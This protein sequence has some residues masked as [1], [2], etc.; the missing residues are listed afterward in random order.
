MTQYRAE[1][2]ASGF[3]LP[4]VRVEIEIEGVRRTGPA[5]VD[6]GTDHTMVPWRAIKDH[7]QLDR[8]LLP[9]TPE[10]T[11]GMHGETPTY[12][13]LG[14]VVRFAGREVC[15]DFL[16]FPRED[17][18]EVVLGLQDF[19]RIFVVQFDWHRQRPSLRIE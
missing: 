4:M 16:V 10:L 1:C 5:L 14:G 18:D 9:V 7:P 19:F 17:E 8:L 11:Y 15:R 12:R 2:D 3:C 6:S 13:C